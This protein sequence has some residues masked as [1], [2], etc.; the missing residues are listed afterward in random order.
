MTAIRFDPIADPYSDNVFQRIKSGLYTSVDTV[1]G[2]KDDFQRQR[3]KDEYRA[4]WFYWAMAEDQ[5]LGLVCFKPYDHALHL[6]LIIVDAALRGQG[7]GKKIMQAIH[8][9]ADAEARTVTL[10]CFRCNTPALHLYQS[11]GYEI[12]S[13]EPEFLLFRRPGIMDSKTDTE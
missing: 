6:H 4:E 12:T 7:V 10:S 1:F 8:H 13:E 11:L 3:I 2:W 9:R 5:C